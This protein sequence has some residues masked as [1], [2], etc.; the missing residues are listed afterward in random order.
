MIYNFRLHSSRA[1]FP[2]RLHSTPCRFGVILFPVTQPLGFYLF[3]NSAS[4][5]SHPAFCIT[6]PIP[7]FFA[8]MHFLLPCNS[9]VFFSFVAFYASSSFFS[10]IVPPYARGGRTLFRFVS[11]LGYFY[12]FMYFFLSFSSQ[13]PRDRTV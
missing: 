10:L 12:S 11:V 5:I 7:C 9:R 6:I 8:L 2:S 13:C 1:R 3:P 4:R